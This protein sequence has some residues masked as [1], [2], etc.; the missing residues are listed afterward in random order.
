MHDP[1]QRQVASAAQLLL[2]LGAL[3]VIL[4]H[5]AHAAPG[6]MTLGA[7]LLCDAHLGDLERAP[8]LPKLPLA[9]RRRPNRLKVHVFCTGTVAV[10]LSQS[11][12]LS[13]G[14]VN[15]VGV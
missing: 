7:I 5:I 13:N 1:P 6:D 8:G 3:A 2:A 12:S 10:R 9:R 11:V 14:W 15:F 4:V